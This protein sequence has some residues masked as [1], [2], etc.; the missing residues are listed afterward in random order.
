VSRDLG[1]VDAIHSVLPEEAAL[2]LG[3]LTQLGDV[4][5]LFGITMLAYWLRPSDRERV[6]VVLGLAFATVA[7]VEA[8]KPL[9]GLP[10]PP[11]P[12]AT[13]ETYPRVLRGLFEATATAGGEGL[14]SGHATLSTVV[15]LGLAGA[16]RVG[17]ARRRM[18]VAIGLIA[19]ISFTRLALGV[20]F[21]VDVVLGTLLG[22]AAIAGL[23]WA[24]TA[25]PVDRPTTAFGIATVVAAGALL[26]TTTNAGG[27]VPHDP[28]LTFAASLGA[29]AAW[30]GVLLRTR[31]SP[32][33]TSSDSGEPSRSRR[34]QA[35]TIVA[36]ATVFGL[37]AL[38]VAG[39]VL[40]D[41]TVAI[42]GA[43]GLAVVAAVA[44]PALVPEF[45]RI[46]R[47]ILPGR[48]R[49]HAGGVRE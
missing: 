31:A 24:T 46:V 17:H 15:W 7:T 44:L 2:L 19:L 1:V 49:D 48:L 47:G 23:A 3:L 30:Q 37:T 5:F 35:R 28:L 20:H 9:F 36:G 29:L 41:W 13:A 6:A 42:A 34:R 11:T 4:W 8:L 43:A 18:A 10:R 14:P 39:A 45:D 25:S 22:L 33:S 21:V 12:L 32:A 26:L 16:V 40:A 38:A 27:A